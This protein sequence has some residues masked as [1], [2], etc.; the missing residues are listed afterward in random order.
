MLNYII[1]NI[2][3]CCPGL[4]STADRTV[5]GLF[6]VLLILSLGGCATPYRYP[7]GQARA[8]LA[9]SQDYAVMDDGYRL[10]L[11]VWRPGKEQ[12]CRAVLL[13]LH[14]LNDYRNAFAEVGPF[15]AGRG[16]TVYA[17]DQRGF[18]ETEGAGYWHGWRRMAQDLR[19][20][21]DLLHRARPACPV[22]VLGESMGGGVILAALNDAPLEVAGKIL[23][24]PAVWSRDTMPWYQRAALWLA[25]HTM[26]GKRLTGEGLDIHPSDNIEM[27]R[28]LGRDPRVIKAT[29]VDVLYG[30]T[31][32]MDM[33]ASAP[34][35]RLGN[36][37]LLYG[38]HDEIVPRE[39]TCR[40]LRRLQQ[41]PG[42]TLIKLY[43]QGYH[44]LMRDLNAGVVLED[45]ASWLLSPNTVLPD[46]QSIEGFCHAPG[47]KSQT[48]SVPRNFGVPGLR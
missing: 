34:L 36:S 18:G 25:V 3:R 31:N 13:A 44:M 10:P 1:N 38:M 16:V 28:A 2:S 47:R 43:P 27:L 7:S 5:G 14:G 22:Y 33:A 37:F 30:V 42:P 15:L 6:A 26:P 17:Y 21:V 11:S 41:A 4:Q 39:P 35:T 40:F 46:R 20:M 12:S 32:L 29:R 9:L 19:E 45:V 24:A 23:V 48:P 8:Q